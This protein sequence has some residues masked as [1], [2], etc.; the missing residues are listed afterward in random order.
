MTPGP[1][2]PLSA[3]PGPSAQVWSASVRFTGRDEGDM[4]HGGRY[5]V[6][7]DAEVEARRRAVVDRPWTWLRQVHGADVVEVR[8][9][10]DGAG[11]R[12]DAAVT[13]EAGCVLAVLVADCA[14]VEARTTTTSRSDRERRTADRDRD[15]ERPRER[16]R[17]RERDRDVFATSDDLDLD[18]DLEGDDDFDVP[19]FLK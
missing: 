17:E 10:G 8:T 7:V 1:S 11:T 12:A 6:D 18:L 4:G 16:A 14:P 15:R 2:G 5:V 13:A 9:P 3:K 19:S